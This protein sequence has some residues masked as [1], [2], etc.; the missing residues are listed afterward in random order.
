MFVSRRKRK[1]NKEININLNNKPLQQALTMKCLGII[2]DKKFKFSEHISYAAER[3][4]KLKHSLS[5]SAKLI[6]GLNHEALQSIYNGAI[7]PLL[8]YGTPVWAEAIRFEYNRLNYIRVQRLINIKI[9]KA[10]RTATNEALCTFTGLTP[11]VIKVEDAAKLHKIMR[12]RE[13]YEIDHKSQPKDWLHPADTVK[14]TEQLEKQDI[15]IY[16]DGSKSENGVGAG[17]AIIIQN[18][19]AHRSL[20]TP[21]N[22]CSN[23]QAEKLAMVKALETIGKLQLND[24]IP[25]F[26]TVHTNNRITLQSLQNENNHNYLI[27]EIRK[28]A[29]NLGKSNWTIK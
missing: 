18:E 1:E 19:L 24:S 13:A 14:V 5:K 17:I 20:Y 12:N 8:F 29:I 16:T 15:Q 26:A 2:I 23:N 10:I 9:T 28:L 27:E 4:S 3:S 6:W 11:V 22:S 7:K 25:R 21:D